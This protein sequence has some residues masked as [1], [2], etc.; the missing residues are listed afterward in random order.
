MGGSWGIPPSEFW[1]PRPPRAISIT[2]VACMVLPRFMANEGRPR[3]ELNVQRCANPPC[4]V[5]DVVER[6]RQS[7]Y[8]TIHPCRV[9]MAR[10]H[11]MPI[12]TR[13][14]RFGSTGLLRQSEFN[15]RVCPAERGAGCRFRGTTSCRARGRARSGPGSRRSAPACLWPRTEIMRVNL[16]STCDLPELLLASVVLD[17]EDQRGQ[18]R[19]PGYP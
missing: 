15:Q 6:L 1:H 2:T 9:E 17:I 3:A 12:V 10:S 16:T 5:R 19:R 11:W 7:A 13:N 14:S 18:C 4:A 8:P